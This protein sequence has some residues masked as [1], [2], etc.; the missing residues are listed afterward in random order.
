MTAPRLLGHSYVSLLIHWYISRAPQTTW[1]LRRRACSSRPNRTWRRPT[2]PDASA[3]AWPERCT[4]RSSLVTLHGRRHSGMTGLWRTGAVSSSV[5]QVAGRRHRR[6]LSWAH[7]ACCALASTRVA[8]PRSSGFSHTRG[9]DTNSVSTA[10]TTSTPSS[11]MRRMQR[12][13]S[14][15]ECS[16]TRQRSSCRLSAP[17]RFESPIRCS[18]TAGRMSSRA[19]APSTF[20]T[21]GAPRP[22]WARPAPCWAKMSM[23]PGGLWPRRPRRPRG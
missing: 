12:T 4:V 3:T 15:T 1:T 6:T 11:A 8:R 10:H 9:A 14:C 5:S 7:G 2:C 21:G 13:S 19:A 23:V 22:S 20:P 17:I 16:C 18:R